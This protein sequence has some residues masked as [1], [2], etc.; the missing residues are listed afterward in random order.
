MKANLVLYITDMP[1]TAAWLDHVF[2]S[3][4]ENGEPFR[5]AA[6]QDAVLNVVRKQFPNEKDLLRYP[7][8]LKLISYTHI[9]Q[10]KYQGIREQGQPGP[11]PGHPSDHERPQTHPSQHG[12]LRHDAV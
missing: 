2:G 5:D 8:Y 3:Y 4:R 10:P 1:T 11:G 12:L 9:M 7:N 6:V